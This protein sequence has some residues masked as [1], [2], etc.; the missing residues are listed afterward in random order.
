MQTVTISQLAEFANAIYF[1]NSI[2]H[3]P[4]GWDVLDVDSVQKDGF[5]A[6]AWQNPTTHEIVIVYRGTVPSNYPT[7]DQDAYVATG[8]VAPA[9]IDAANF[10]ERVAATANTNYPG[11]TIAVTGHSLGG[12]QAQAA[13]VA[14]D[15]NVNNASLNPYAVV[16][17]APGLPQSLL[18]GAAASSFDALSIYSQGDVIHLAGINAAHVGPLPPVSV[19]AGPSILSEWSSASAAFDI[20]LLGGPVVALAAAAASLISDWGGPAHKMQ[21]LS[22][23]LATAAVGGETESY[24]LAHNGATSPNPNLTATSGGA[25]LIQDGTLGSSIITQP[26]T[27]AGITNSGVGTISSIGDLVPSSDVAAASSEFAV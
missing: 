22:D 19:A 15:E 11:Y 1:D 8:A 16:F 23:F 7:L 2:A 14:L 12:Y 9:A 21:V 3:I 4:A 17:N 10:A 13:L 18:G 26:S 6:E 27:S 24:Y 20:G 25:F 5:F